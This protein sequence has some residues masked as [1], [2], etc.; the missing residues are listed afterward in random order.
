V[1]EGRIGLVGD[2]T[3]ID[4]SLVKVLVGSSFLPVISSVALDP[5]GRSLNV[6]A[7]I[8]AGEVL[9]P[10]PFPY[11]PLSV[12]GVR[13]SSLILNTFLCCLHPSYRS[14]HFLCQFFPFPNPYVPLLSSPTT[15][16]WP[17]PWDQDSGGIVSGANH[18]K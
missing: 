9:P 6:N 8:A 14:G 17:L 5:Q 13:T 15:C 18:R 11:P 4:A 1:L 3:S 2:I 12:R 7:D 16:A 10:A